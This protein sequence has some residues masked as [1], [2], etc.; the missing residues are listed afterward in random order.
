VLQ[1]QAVVLVYCLTAIRMRG[2]L[3]QRQQQHIVC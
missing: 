1:Q 3:Q 2:N